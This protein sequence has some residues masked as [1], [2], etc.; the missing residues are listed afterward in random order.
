MRFGF[1]GIEE[2]LRKFLS[3]PMKTLENKEFS[4]FENPNLFHVFD[5][6]AYKTSYFVNPKI[7][8][9]YKH[10]NHIVQSGE[11]RIALHHFHKD[12]AS[13]IKSNAFLFGFLH[14][15]SF[16]FSAMQTGSAV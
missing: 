2:K 3:K 4:I 14:F 11:R 15:Y 7:V 12:K 8:I 5:K 10:Q 13:I 1:W 9:E 6:K 16:A